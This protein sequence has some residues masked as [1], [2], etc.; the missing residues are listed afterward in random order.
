MEK[1]T[2]SRNKEDFFDFIRVII[3]IIVGRRR[4]MVSRRVGCASLDVDTRKIC[5]Y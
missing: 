4:Q 2:E 1:E 3:I 5:M